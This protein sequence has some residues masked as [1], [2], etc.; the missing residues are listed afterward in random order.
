MSHEVHLNMTFFTDRKV[1]KYLYTYII[2]VVYNIGTYIIDIL[3][4]LFIIFS[5][6]WCDVKFE[7]SHECALNELTGR[8]H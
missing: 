6:A 1:K 2:I 5:V 7:F 8:S 3:L 4:L